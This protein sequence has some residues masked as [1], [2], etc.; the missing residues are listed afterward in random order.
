MSLARKGNRQD[1][2]HVMRALLSR[3]DNV[4]KHSIMSAW[5][6]GLIYL[7]SSSPVNSRSP[8]CPGG[9]IPRNH[10]CHSILCLC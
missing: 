1:L 6:D 5:R 2:L 9:F 7:T 3:G 4:N 10:S 8:R